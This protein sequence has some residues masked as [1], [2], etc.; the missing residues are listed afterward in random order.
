MQN[1][2]KKINDPKLFDL[3]DSV[4]L[5]N[6]E[7]FKKVLE[8]F[9]NYDPSF[10][11]L[12]CY[13]KEDQPKNRRYI[14]ESY[15]K[16]QQVLDHNF[17]KIFA[18][19]GNFG[20]RMWELILCDVLSASGEFEP[21]K[22]VGADFILKSGANKFIQ[23]EAIAPD[24]ASNTK[25][26]AVRPDYSTNN[27]FSIGGQIHDME[28]PIALRALQA[29]SD[30]KD[31]YNKKLPIILAINSHKAVGTVSDDGYI[32]RRILFGLGNVTLTKTKN[33]KY[34]KGFEQ[35]PYYNKPGEKPFLVAYFRRPEFNH[36]SGVIYTS[37]NPLGFIPGGYSWHNSGITFIPNPNATNPIELDFP[38]FKR[39]ICNEKIYKEFKPLKEF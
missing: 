15:S 30:K 1:F 19:K 37:Q 25:L 35:L 28:R 9:P 20:S 18:S 27:F 32:L 5:S 24:E 39:I 10:L 11:W 36:I 21:K 33:G 31:G 2:L 8:Q 6:I 34:L 29:F 7:S 14:E 26:R 12:L 3:I 16:F 17:P 22:A 4:P 38:Y 23:I 13:S